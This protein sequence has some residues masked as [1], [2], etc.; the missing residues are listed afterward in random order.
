[1]DL[2]EVND[3]N[4][5]EK[6]DLYLSRLKEA[7]AKNPRKK[8]DEE[9]VANLSEF[10]KRNRKLLHLNIEST[11]LTEFILYELCRSLTRAQSIL[12]LHASNNPGIT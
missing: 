11:Q 8:H 5:R 10:I 12:S 9:I 7:E 3:L 4:W 6:H 1:M 2:Q